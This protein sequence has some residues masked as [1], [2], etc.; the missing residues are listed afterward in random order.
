MSSVPGPQHVAV[1]PARD[2]GRAVARR[3]Q[4]GER[5]DAGLCPQDAVAGRRP[6]PAPVGSSVR[7]AP[8][9]REID[10]YRAAAV[11]GRELAAA[12]MPTL[13]VGLLSAA[14][15]DLRRRRARP[16]R[17]RPCS[18]TSPMRV[19]HAGDEPGFGRGAQHRAERGAGAGAAAQQ[20]DR[21]HPGAA[22]RRRDRPRRRGRERQR[23]DAADR[24]AQHAAR[25]QRPAPPR[26]TP[27]CRISATSISTSFPQLM[28]IRVVVERPQRGTTSSPIPASSSSARRPSQLAFDAAGH[29]QRRRRF[30]TPTR[31]R[32]RSA[33]LTLVSPSGGT[34][35]LIADKSIRSGKIAAYIDMRD[36]VLV[37]A[38]NQLDE[39]AAAMAR[40]LSDRD[41]RRHGR[42]RRRADRLR[43]RYRG[44][45][46]R[47]HASI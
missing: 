34:V 26:R 30:G 39:L 15:A 25:R 10:Q 42:Q 31:P 1:R 4:R 5:A 46:A 40:A 17:S 28:D 19:Q 9:N 6:P 13:R 32:A 41:R 23:R 33:R 20:H 45:L 3:R 2:A 7:V 29:G 35:D 22:R 37:Q 11:A 27:R 36:H 18:T 16:A 43:C 12:P 24:D 44:L 8:I 14:A 38:Q 21:R 47:Q